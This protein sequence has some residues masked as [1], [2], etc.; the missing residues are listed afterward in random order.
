MFESK[1][2][3][4]HDWRAQ[5]LIPGVTMFE[6]DFHDGNAWRPSTIFQIRNV[7]L[8][9]GRNFDEVYVAQRYYSKGGTIKDEMG[10]YKGFGKT[11]DE[12]CSVFSPRLQPWGS[13]C[14]KTD[15]EADVLDLE[16]EQ[17]DIFQ[18][19]EGMTRV[20]AVPRPFYCKSERY[21]FFINLFGNLGGF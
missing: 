13:K 6:C 8:M 17:D 20:F 16:E 2:K 18:T 1:S 4:D 9:G 15:T 7:K 10:S 5:Y 3:A 14:G 12:W 11:F 21:L 19:H